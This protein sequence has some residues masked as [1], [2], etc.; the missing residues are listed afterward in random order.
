MDGET[1]VLEIQVVWNIQSFPGYF[2]P[3]V[4]VPIRIPSIRPVDLLDKN[5][6]LPPHKQQKPK[7]WFLC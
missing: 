2:C 4:L 5:V 1:P 3:R 6:I 7:V